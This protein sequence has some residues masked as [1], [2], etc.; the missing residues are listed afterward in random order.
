MN[1]INP[2]LT[3]PSQVFL[4]PSNQNPGAPNQNLIPV[5]QPLRQFTLVRT[6]NQN[7]VLVNQ[8]LGRLSVEG[9][10]NQEIT[11]ENVNFL[12]NG[13]LRLQKQVQSQASELLLVKKKLRV[14]EMQKL[15]TA[16]AFETYKTASDERAQALLEKVEELQKKF[17]A[18]KRE[19]SRQAKFVKCFAQYVQPGQNELE[20]LFVAHGHG[21][22]NK[23]GAQLTTFIPNN[24][25]VPND[26]NLKF[27]ELKKGL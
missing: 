2:T 20:A 22:Y 12:I 14:A 4:Q 19:L 1:M 27:P 24:A 7:L 23:Y 11:I 26:P 3:R 16:Q 9:I 8:V 25:V 15:E 21:Y 18:L 10:S 17:S 5:N 13:M 6:P